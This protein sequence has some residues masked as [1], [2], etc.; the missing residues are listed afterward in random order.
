MALA[1]LRS[2]RAFSFASGVGAAALGCGA[3]YLVCDTLSDVV[4]LRACQALVLP[5][6]AQSKQLAGELGTP[7]AAGPMFSA[8]LR[9]SETGRLVQCQFRLDGTQRSSDATATVRRPPYAS[10]FLYN[11]TGPG[12]WE[13]LHCHVLVGAVPGWLVCARMAAR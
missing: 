10:S 13:L 11:L 5:L 2:S 6:A 12:T 9:V 1:R 3:V 7:I 4:T 8:R